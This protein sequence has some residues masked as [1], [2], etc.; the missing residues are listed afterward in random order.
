M[1]RLAGHLGCSLS[2]VEKMPSREFNRWIAYERIEPF[3]SRA[4]DYMH[5]RTQ[6]VLSELIGSYMYVKRY[7]KQR[8]RSKPADFMYKRPKTQ[9]EKL[10]EFVA[11]LSSMAKK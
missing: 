2:E 4:E 8:P 11:N 6:A 1:F 9:K 5:A 3:G 10:G 7:A